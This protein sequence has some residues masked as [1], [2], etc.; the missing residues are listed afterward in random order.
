MIRLTSKYTGLMKGWAALWLVLMV[1][2][3]SGGS[4][5]RECSA[6]TPCALQ[7]GVD[8]MCTASPLS[9]ASFCAYEDR[10]CPFLIRW[11]ALAGDG[12]AGMCVDRDLADASVADA[13]PDAALPRF[14]PRG[15]VTGGPIAGKLSVYAIDEGTGERIDGVAVRVGGALAGSPLTATTG[16]DGLA[17]FTAAQLSGPQTVTLARTGYSALTWIGINASELTIPLRSRGPQPTATVHGTIT[18]WDSIPVAANHFL[19]ATIVY[20]VNAGDYRPPPA[21]G[22]RNVAGLGDV[23]KNECVRGMLAT[24]VSDCTFTLTTRVGPQFLIAAI[25]DTDFRTADPADDVASVVGYALTSLP[26]VTAGQDLTSVALTQVPSGDLASFTASYSNLPAGQSATHL[27]FDA[28]IGNQVVNIGGSPPSVAATRSLAVIRPGS[29]SD[30]L[31][32]GIRYDLWLAALPSATQPFPNSRVLKERADPA[33]PVTAATWLPVPTDLAVSGGLY[34]FTSPAGANYRFS[35]FTVG[36]ELVWT[37]GLFDGS[38]SFRLPSL[39][40]D[41]MPAGTIYWYCS[42]VEV[43][44]WTPADFS[45]AA[46]L[47]APTSW[48]AA[49]ITFTH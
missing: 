19:S 12:L 40:P 37:V 36:S 42:A 35:D 33:Q 22:T 13:G 43:P 44:G 39:T 3:C 6:E 2:G 11:G 25:I 49:S 31:A 48:S 47:Q 24:L 15:G 46:T 9:T 27:G 32:G 30:Q 41:P 21:Q 5:S 18:G 1:G 28:H 34:S 16:A 10:T 17:T 45:I 7:N 8:G 20:T 14:I 26:A 4:R 38:T 23:A 29:T